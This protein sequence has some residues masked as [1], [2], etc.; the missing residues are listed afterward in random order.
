MGLLDRLGLRKKHDDFSMDSPGSSPDANA[1]PFAPQPNFGQQGA[2][3]DGLGTNPP[4]LGLPPDPMAQQGFDQSGVQDPLAQQQGFGHSSFNPNDVP[5]TQGQQMAQ[6]F[7]Q[8]QQP[9][10]QQA[11]G[12]QTQNASPEHKM[13]VMNLKLDAIRSELDSLT[14]HIKKLEAILEHSGAQKRW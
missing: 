11:L 14:Q 3:G 2:Q 10:Q 1:D 9:Q 4:D 13:E 12:G 5:L 8:Q 7:V 6:Q